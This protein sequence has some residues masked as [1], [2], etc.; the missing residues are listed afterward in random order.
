MT[1]DEMN[2]SVG[3]A[4]PYGAVQPRMVT[5]LWAALTGALTAWLGFAP[6]GWWWFPYFRVCCARGA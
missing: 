6:V 3:G 5:A 2:R 1:N 4:A